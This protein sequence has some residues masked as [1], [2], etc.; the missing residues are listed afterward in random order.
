MEEVPVLLFREH[1]VP[2]LAPL[3]GFEYDEDEAQVNSDTSIR[4]LTR[5]ATIMM[6]GGQFVLVTF[7]RPS[8]IG[9]TLHIIAD[10]PD[11]YKPNQLVDFLKDFGDQCEEQQADRIV[12]MF[13]K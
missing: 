9:A 5:L 1:Q 11:G 3:P 7:N 10:F 6:L 4:R 12:G 13:G 2:A 8:Q